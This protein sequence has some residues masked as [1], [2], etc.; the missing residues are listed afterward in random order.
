MTTA[1][2]I[3]AA[4]I[5]L[6]VAATAS[7]SPFSVSRSNPTVAE[8]FDSMWD[9]A[10]GSASLTLPEGWVIDRNLTAPRTIGT[11][12]SASPE[13]MYEGGVSLASN[14]K[15]GTW[16]F[17]SSSDPSDRAIGG[18]TTTVA[19]GTRCISLMT[20]VR[21]DAQDPIN[22]FNISYN[23]EKYRY[24]ANSAGF[25]VQM[26]YSTDGENWI[27]AGDNFRT[28]F[29]ADAETIGAQ[30][31]P[32]AITSVA[33][34]DLL[35]DVAP[36]G[37]LYLAWNISVASGTSPDKA[38]GLALDDITVSARF[39]NPN[40]HT[41]YIENA[42]GKS[43]LSV[44][45]TTTDFFGTAPGASSSL[46][47]VVNGVRYTAWDMP[48]NSFDLYVCSGGGTYGPVTVDPS[49]DAYYCLSPSGLTA[50]T[51]PA[52][53]TGWVDPNR[54]PFVAS[55]YYLR[56][57]INSWG[58]DPEWEFSNEGNG[59][60]VLYDKE[61]SGAFKIAD[62]DWGSFNYGSNGSNAAYDTPY[63]LA[64]G[65][66]ANISCGGNTFVCKRI[67][68]TLGS[69]GEAILLLEGDDSETDLTSV[70]MI[71]DFNSWNSMS[72]AG[73]LKLDEADG[74]FKGRVTMKGGDNGLSAWRIYQRLGMGGSWG[75]SENATAATTRGNLEKG[76]TGNAAAIPATYDVTFSLS[77]GSYSFAKVESSPSV[78]TLNPAN[79]VLTPQNPK[80]VKVLSLNNSLIHYNDQDFV[81]NDIA[82]AM[83]TDA[84]W[85]KHTNLGKPLSYH[86][87]EGD[88]LAG[89]GTPGAK[90]MI[91]SEAWS[92]IILQ[93]QSSLPRTKPE[94]F[95]A[96]VEQWIGYIRQY[97]P[98]PN[99]VIILPVNWAYSSDWDNFTAYNERF[100]DVYNDVAS[101]FGAVVVP[102]A[103]AYSDILDENGRDVASE[104]FSD[105]RHPTP[106]AT[107]MAACMEYAAITGT[108]PINITYTPAD[109]SAEEGATMRNYA[110]KAYNSY[111][112]T[113]NHLGGTI[114]FRTRILDD[115]GIEYPTDGITYSVD[116][117]GSISPQ[118]Q[119]VSDG[120]RGTFTVTATTADF[121]KTAT[122]NVTDH[123]TEVVTYPAIVLNVDNLSASQDFNG[124][125]DAADATLPDTWRIDR[126]TVATR[127]LGT[128]ATAQSQTTYAGGV[129]LPS[130]AKNGLWN[131]GTDDSADR[132]IGGITTGVANGTRAVNVYTHLLND[133]RKKLENVT[134]TYDIEKYRKGNNAA[135]FAVQLYYSY[136][137][138]NWT[139]AG[140]DFYTFLPADNATEGYSSVP[141]ETIPVSA[142]LPVNLEPGLDVYLAWNISVASG[143]AAQGAMALAID[144]FKVN[145]S[146][147]E[148]PV[149]KHYIY[150]DN[151]TTWT[152]LGLYAYGDS[153]FYGAWPG[154][155]P[156]DKK[157]IN[158]TRFQVFGLD[159]DKGNYNLIFNNWNNNKQLPDFPITADKDY[160]LKIDD[161][162]VNELKDFTAG[163]LSVSADNTLG[164]SSNSI[165]NPSRSEVSIFNI[166]GMLVKVSEESE[167]DLN[168]IPAGIYVVNSG[169]TTLKFIKK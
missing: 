127:T 42:S 57:E 71:G 145:A 14:A 48:D 62:A 140:S 50:I 155:E 21:N 162:G 105:D 27:S 85:T 99:A 58:A 69:N 66:D 108:D 147:P 32:I 94:T 150:V 91:R 152:A 80:S 51:D 31:V 81:F 135:G 26:Y 141:G 149:C 166:N 96:N 146:V 90:M 65:T 23:I 134:L 49:A 76:L 20:S 55:G 118:G 4:A 169:D 7:A 158:G 29:A 64:G 70:Y 73:E 137:G 2:R 167:I 121:V 61:L 83:G 153:E 129:S 125:G 102:V 103:R 92:H 120:S 163:L 77:D 6:A 36:G 151:Q 56:G 19:N 25:A 117:G 160:Y 10:N 68:L 168:P 112:N 113:V 52:V 88:G 39:A 154:A 87:E 43:G 143:E 131:F 132:A 9:A 78:M 165:L 133:G 75:L 44:Y 74:L 82:R 41:L 157:D 72:T 115:F 17:G 11:W 164:F 30:T 13:V 38:P 109:L 60:Y 130:N 22:G 148:V 144:N 119:F 28:L 84:S 34:K 54:K 136:D 79:A 67:V 89:D 139:S 142:V 59:S 95:R 5:T 124:I 123:A 12:N 97:C 107:Y 35:A 138:R 161:N 1:R 16:N 98:N 159:T 86:W 47:K 63:S 100:L 111:T 122:V 114:N 116:G 18:L 53:Y 45:S 126:Q 24:G 40:Q 37:V 15:N 33:A 104:M 106:K 128:Y 156:I 101:E 46:S 3:M 93:E 110:S 8:N